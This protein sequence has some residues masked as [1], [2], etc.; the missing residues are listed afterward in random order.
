MFFIQLAIKR[1]FKFAPRP[2]CVS[3]LPG[4]SKT[5]KTCIKINPKKSINLISPDLWAPAVGQIHF[6]TVVQQC[7]VRM[8]IN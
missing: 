2:M 3:A 8:L 1:L 6:L 5:G 7:S 4:K